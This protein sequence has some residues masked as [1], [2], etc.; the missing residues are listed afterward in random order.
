MPLMQTRKP[1]H[2]FKDTNGHV[3]Q[4][5]PLQAFEDENGKIR[6][7]TPI[8][9]SKTCK[10]CKDKPATGTKIV[11]AQMQKVTMPPPEPVKLDPSVRVVQSKVA[12]GRLGLS[13]A[14][15]FGGTVTPPTCVSGWHFISASAP[16]TITVVTTKPIR[17]AG[18]LNKSATEPDVLSAPV[19]FYASGNFIGQLNKPG[20]CTLESF[21]EFLLWPGEHLLDATMNSMTDAGSLRTVWAY[22]I[23]EKS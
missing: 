10:D 17:L 2:T 22:K 11:N 13:G 12:A 6:Y 16:S 3:V 9:S 7:G 18:F 8:L 14:D 4:G 19:S 23:D 5:T 1:T 20:D 21:G 15:G